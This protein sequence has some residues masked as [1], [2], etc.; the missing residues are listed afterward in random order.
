MAET[1]IQLGGIQDTSKNVGPPIQLDP[2]LGQNN[3]YA[4]PA[5]LVDQRA[6][7]ASY[8]LAPTVAAK[9]EEDFKASIGSGFEKAARED[10]A[11][12]LNVAKSA[13]ANALI[14]SK[15][16]DAPG[17]LT[18]EDLKWI[19]GTS[20]FEAYDPKTVFEHNYANTYVSELDK[21]A[22]KVG[23]DHFWNIAQQYTPDEFTSTRQFG[24]E[25]IA[26]NQVLDTVSQDLL[27]EMHQQSYLG[28]TADILKMAFPLFNPYY[29]YKM[30]GNVEGVSFWNG[31]LGTN[32][33]EQRKALLRKPFPE[34]VSAL[35]EIVNNLRKDNP[36]L[37]LAFVESL[38]GQST[39]DKMLND[40]NTLGHLTE[41]GGMIKAGASLFSKGEI[42]NSVRGATKDAIH[43]STSP[44]Q[45]KPNTLASVGDIEQ[46]A[47]EN[48]ATKIKAELKGTVNPAQDA[49]ERL[50]AHMTAE[51]NNIE[52]NPGELTKARTNILREQIE[53]R[54]SEF[55][56][57]TA[58]MSRIDRI[59]FD[60]ASKEIIAQ[61]HNEI[62]GVHPEIQF[63][64]L[65]DPFR[66]PYSNS[67]FVRGIIGN[68]DG[69]LF[70]YKKVAREF[71]AQNGIVNPTIGRKGGGFYIEVVKPVPENTTYA[72][73]FIISEDRPSSK[74]VGGYPNAVIG[75]L[76]TA[77]DTM[78]AEQ[79]INRKTT[80]YTQS[81]LRALADEW[82]TQ[83]RDV[84]KGIVR[85]DEFGNQIP[86]Y[87][88]SVPVISRALKRNEWKQFKQMLEDTN[89][90][91]DPA[92]NRPGLSFDN[93][94]DLQ[95]YYLRNFQR[96]PSWTETQAYF[97]TRDLNEMDRML[98]EIAVHR[99]QTRL[100]AETHTVIV[101]DKS[102]KQLK[103]PKF[104]AIRM[105]HMPSTRDSIAIMG[106]V[107]GQED[108][109][110]LPKLLATRKGR[111]KAGVP[112]ENQPGTWA[113]YNN[114]VKTGRMKLL[115]IYNPEELPLNGF[116][117]IKDQKI[118]YVL[119]KNVDTEPLSWEQ[120][121]RLGGFHRD[122]EYD[123]YAK[124]A[125][126][127]REVVDG[128]TKW[129]Y[130]GDRTLF[131]VGVREMGEKSIK[132]INEF[133]RL[134][135]ENKVGEAKAYSNSG[136]LPWDWSEMI[137]KIKPKKVDGKM[138]R[139]V[140]DINEP[141]HITPK[142]T[143]IVELDKN[144]ERRYNIKAPNSF[145]DG[146]KEGSDARAFQVEYTGQRDSDNF[147]GLTD[148]G[149]RNNPVFKL[150]Q[151]KLID[152]LTTLNRSL[153]RIINS[154]FMDDY[155]ISAITAWLKEA[156]P[157]LKIEDSELKSAPFYHFKTITEDSFKRIKDRK[158]I[159]R[160][161]ANHLKINQLVG[162][163]HKLDTFLH[164]IAQDLADSIYNKFGPKASN[165]T[166]AWLMPTLRDPFQYARSWT[167]NAYLGLFSVPQ[168]FVQNMTWASIYAISPR[169][170]TRGSVATILQQ[171]ARFN[172]HPNIINFLDKTASKFGWRPGEWLEAMKEGD[173]TGFFNV[174][175]EVAMLDNQRTA[176]VIKNG[177]D[178]FLSWG[179]IPFR[180]GE[181]NVR[182]GAW[183]TAFK[184]WRDANP[185]AK[186][187][188]A[189][190]NKILDRAD[191]LYGNMSTA[192]NSILHTGVLS[193]ATQFYAYNIRL[194]E[195]FMSGT[196]RTG[197]TLA[198]RNAV[199]A[200]MVGTYSLLFGVPG[201]LGLSGAPAGDWVRKQALEGRFGK[202]D[203]GPI[204]TGG[205][206]TKPYVIGD[207]A[208][209]TLFYE[210]I[211][212]MLGNFLTGHWYNIGPRYGVG[213][214]TQA[215]DLL[216]SDAS[217]WSILFGASGS[218]I[219][220]TAANS[221][222]LLMLLQSAV[223]NNP[224]MYKPKVDDA[225]D[226]LKEISVINRGWTTL[227][228]F[229]TGKW[230]NKNS[231]YIE[232]V[233]KTDAFWRF[234]SG[235]SSQQQTDIHIKNLT[236]KDR[237]ELAAYGR[238]KFEQE[239]NRAL[240]AASRKDYEQATEYTYRAFRKL[241]WSGWP[242]DKMGGPMAD[243]ARNGMSLIK[244]TDMNYYLN[245]MQNVTPE[246]RKSLMEAYGKIQAGKK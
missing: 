35:T 192:S 51:A 203:F 240:L 105:S 75:N 152:P 71:A 94:K 226:F 178:T 221:D 137:D 202:F 77:E 166:P 85:T 149:S 155:K 158:I 39:S 146:T 29:E 24:Y 79:R 151:A 136:A 156:A 14:Q 9:P 227:V 2:T 110:D 145:R 210:G 53:N 140:L 128:V 161:M 67:W 143:A 121:N 97:A 104:S 21:F 17:P 130:E 242:A 87:R 98:R 18:M 34:F 144:L 236:L 147:K 50:G 228:A 3:T 129:H 148:I 239:M 169:A 218:L 66:E 23:D 93:P 42:L 231:A 81:V 225:I 138:V 102:G 41:A 207:S 49:Y 133:F 1:P 106:D 83:I 103:T 15:I 95:D 25:T 244:K 114:E 59:P 62:K 108:V 43:A 153:S 55:L 215:R 123:N 189:E 13:T 100:G 164:G 72:D 119:A 109:K 47:I 217:F 65:S 7:K 150:E 68:S 82:N 234:V 168:L 219:A 241:E 118:R 38:K 61:I 171:M 188:Q 70:K 46:A 224:K 184:E 160:L 185:T 196:G 92:T 175:G 27:T 131:G 176:N 74:S 107:V 12:M 116:G 40:V 26:Q 222:G 238:K 28:R 99:N 31:L 48:A 6:Y 117:K 206:S 201:A 142:N 30:R 199:R 45:S 159:D 32:L 174:A 125:I 8:G 139:P 141:V 194:A 230:I 223:T 57:R 198:E 181:R 167:F 179:L 213:G 183:Y 229:Q 73:K 58:E 208:L 214:L 78:S 186:I 111:K 44:V 124:Q 245:K 90:S 126:M 86:W 52:M 112:P 200:R 56:T 134:M 216:Y 135:R 187:T 127:R 191:L 180:E 10:A 84:A 22:A 246:Q 36:S 96:L 190:R 205:I 91:I 195:I 76:R 154:T 63:L 20:K 177:K 89:K 170:A 115:R 212:A 197:A 193:T 157:H 33:D 235:L 182:Y 204:H 220:N 64:N 4:V 211:P 60:E 232:D 243:V 11:S 88:R 5:E 120:V 209:Q 132:N 173:R 69:G 172:R 80:I 37:A 101:T 19:E 162:T 54:K 16:A 233:T 163:P 122:F 113:Y 165:L 237:S